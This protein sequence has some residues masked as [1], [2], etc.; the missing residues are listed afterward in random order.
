MKSVQYTNV[1]TVDQTSMTSG[2]SYLP[3]DAEFGHI[4]QSAKNKVIYTPDDYREI[5]FAR[6]NN[7][8]LL[9]RLVGE[10]ILNTEI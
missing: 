2:H 4:K 8:V 9:I 6:K 3:N 5:I 10:E 7:K 1:D